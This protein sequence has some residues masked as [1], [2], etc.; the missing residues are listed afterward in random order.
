MNSTKFL[1]SWF[2][3][4]AFDSEGN[5]LNKTVIPNKKVVTTTQSPTGGTEQVIKGT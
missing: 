3:T 4:Q 5:L 1:G 2:T